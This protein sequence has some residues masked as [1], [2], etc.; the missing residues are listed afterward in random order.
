[1][2][3]AFILLLLAA[4][5]GGSETA[6]VAD[7]GTTDAG[8]CGALGADVAVEENAS[9]YPGY[10]IDGCRLAYVQ[11]GSHRLVL[12]DLATGTES[13]RTDAVATNDDRPRRPTLCADFVAWEV[14]A[15]AASVVVI[16]KNGI[17]KKVMG[18]FDHAGEP[19]AFGTSVVFTAWLE[20]DALGDTDVLVYDTATD[21]TVVAAGGMG[22]QRFADVNEK[23]VVAS[24]CSEDPDGRYDGNDTDLADVVV[25]DRATKASTVRK[26]PGKQA[27]PV[28]VG[29]DLFGYLHWSDVHPEP[30]FQAF[31]VRGARVGTDVAAD[32]KIADVTNALRFWLPSGHRGTLDWISPDTDGPEL[33]WRAPVDGSTVKQ[34][35]LDGSFV[36]APQSS[37]GLTVVAVRV[38]GAA[39]LKSVAR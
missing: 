11:A 2:K 6:R 39:I 30:K 20:P 4:C 33:L 13:F 3:R 35:V 37:N 8:A 25:F 17:A 7:G 16:S 9:I 1:M 29:D 12:R 22:Q 34:S 15:A 14:G 21:S 31:G 24:Y 27:F 32:V 26:A 28:L 19:R 36:G 23:Y 5:S 10:A 38:S 18:A